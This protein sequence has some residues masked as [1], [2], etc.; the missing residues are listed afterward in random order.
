LIKYCVAAGAALA[1]LGFWSMSGNDSERKLEVAGGRTTI[2]FYPYLLQA[3]GLKVEENPSNIA[4]QNSAEDSEG[5]TIVFSDL[6]FTLLDGQLSKFDSGHFSHRGGFRL[7]SG[8]NAIDADQFI[9]SG[10]RSVANQLELWVDR[11]DK[12]SFVAFELRNPRNYFDVKDKVLSATGMD[13]H[14]TARAAQELGRPDLA[15]ALVGL[16]AVYAQTKPIDGKGDVR[17]YQPTN[18]GRGGDSTL[19]VAI[20]RLDSLVSLGR[21]GTYPNGLNGLSMLTT[22]CNVG[23]VN[24]PWSAPM[25]VNH[26]VIAMNLYRVHEGRFEQIGWSWLKHG[27]LATNSGGC[28]S[29]QNP[30]TG[31]LLGP[32]C[33]DTYGTGNNGDR[34]YLGGRDE[35]NPFTGVW[36]CEGSWF[37]NYVNDCVRRNNGSGLDAVAHRLVVRD[38]DLGITGARYFYEAFYICQNDHDRY[39]AISHREATTAWSAGQNRWNFTTLGAA[40]TMGPAINQWGEMRTIAQ[41]NIEG[42]VIVGVQTT[43]L[44]NGM[45]RYEYAV[46][47]HTLDRQVREFRVPMPMGKTVQNIGFRDIDDDPTNQWSAVYANGAITWSTGNFGSSG[48]NP[49]K[50]SSVFNFRFDA[51]VPPVDS[52]VRMGLFKPGTDFTLVS[53][54]KAPLLLQPV[55]SFDPVNG[56][57]VAG[58]LQSLAAQDGNYLTIQGVSA[59]GV[60]LTTSTTAPSANPTSFLL[61]VVSATGQRSNTDQKIELWNW[62]TSQWELVDTRSASVNDALTLVTISANPARFVHGTSREVRARLIYISSFRDI[63]LRLNFDQIGFQFN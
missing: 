48:A 4:D 16:V 14:I 49:L 55:Q 33:S 3:N 7:V 60:G 23:A 19:D 10:S 51:N 13:M 1:A 52:T 44:G 27:F 62:S 35:V 21:V 15:D 45:F 25:N 57:V 6:K 18:E 41:P 9:I 5:Y 46:Y 26:P 24:I 34:F 38:Q 37:S 56:S 59:A 29:C 8:R 12:E 50:Y 42:D 2:G 11:G 40:H 58:N 30:G 32:G 53:V 20:S 47:N 17:E 54:T 61:G 63:G 31:S 43:A 36:T 28:G 22:S 39:N